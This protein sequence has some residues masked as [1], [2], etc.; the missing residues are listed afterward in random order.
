DV[1]RGKRVKADEDAAVGEKVGGFPT[2]KVEKKKEEPVN[3][4]ENGHPKE[5][6]E[7][8]DNKERLSAQMKKERNQKKYI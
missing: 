1:G 4:V 6:A 8:D 2:K 7:R 3:K 5:R